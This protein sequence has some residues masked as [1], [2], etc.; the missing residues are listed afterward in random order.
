MSIKFPDSGIDTSWLCIAKGKT[1]L[2]LASDFILALASTFRA[3]FLC[4]KNP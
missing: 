1:D 4:K 3:P 2:S